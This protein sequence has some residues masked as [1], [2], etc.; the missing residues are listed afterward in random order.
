MSRPRSAEADYIVVRL[1]RC[2]V[3]THI[4]E[5]MAPDGPSGSRLTKP[6]FSSATEE[7]WIDCSRHVTASFH[8][9]DIYVGRRANDGRWQANGLSS[10]HLILERHD[11]GLRVDLVL[12]ELELSPR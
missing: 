10:S 6:L 8:D 4:L 1:V 12:A 11:S 2:I 3:F 7:S 5:K 9:P